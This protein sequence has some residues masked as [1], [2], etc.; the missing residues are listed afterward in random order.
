MTKPI[1]IVELR[2][3]RCDL[4]FGV[5]T[6][7]ATGSPKCV[8][9]YATCGAKDVYNTDG[10][11]RWYFSRPGDPLVITA[12]MPSADEWYG[13]CIPILRGVSTDPTRINLGAVRETESPFGLRGQ[14]SVSLDDFEFRN[15]FGDFYQSERTIRGS[16]GRLLLAWLGE[17]VSQMELR[18]YT[19]FEGDALADMTVRRY[20]LTNIAPPSGGTWKLTGIDPLARASRKKAEFP[21][22]TDLQLMTAISATTTEISVSG[23]ESD[24]SDAFG[25][26]GYFYGRVNAEIIRYS[27][28]TGSAGE[29]TLTDVQR[30]ALGTEAAAHDIEDGMQRCAHYHQ[31][32]YWR[33]VYDI[34]TNHTTLEAA[35]IP[36]ATEWTDEGNSYLPT[37]RGTGTFT[38]PMAAEEACAIAMRDGMFSIWWDE[39]AQKVKMKALRQPTE[40]P[41]EYNERNAIV[42]SAI[43]RTPDDRRTRVTIYYDR[44]DPT[45][46]MGEAK[47][48]ATQRIRID[49]EAEGADYA[50]GTVRNLTWYSPLVRSNSNAILVQASFLQR[51]RSTPEYIELT[52]SAKDASV[53]VGDVI[54]VTSYDVIDMLGNPETKAWQVIEWEEVSPNFEYRVLAQSFTLF[55]RPAFIMDNSAPDFATATDAEKINACYITEN[56]GTMPDGTV[57][58]V[59]Q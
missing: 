48:Y 2:Q 57:G 4:R 46:G 27:G 37:L 21:R 17:A 6:C 15:Q 44:R 38:E 39:R 24:V 36:F 55:E 18:L 35:L 10:E 22:S 26:D 54:S 40:T 31:F 16:L 20:D 42:S 23:A 53:A 11:L 14:I 56:D 34:L 51:Y 25:N 33:M 52:L 19:G 1:Q 28:Y 8:Q 58:Y 7:T 50:D 5:G 30:G 9:T 59:I 49:A 47:N 45:D 43:K 3:P 12:D 41:T 13:P 32:Q 29:W